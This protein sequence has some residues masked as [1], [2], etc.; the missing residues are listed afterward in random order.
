MIRK[1][2]FV[3]TVAALALLTAAAATPV[4]DPQPD[5]S[6][7]SATQPGMMGHGMMMGRGMMGM[8]PGIMGQGMMGQGMM[9]PGMMNDG[10]TGAIG[11]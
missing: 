1:Q 6:S 7:G 9:G 11:T 2:P 4:A 8:G 3:R 10:C 5:N